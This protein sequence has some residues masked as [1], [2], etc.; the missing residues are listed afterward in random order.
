MFQ[1]NSNNKTL[2]ISEGD[3]S[4]ISYEI[5]EK[6]KNKILDFSNTH[7]VFLVQTQNRFKLNFAQ[8]IQYEDLKEFSN[9]KNG[10]YQ[11]SILNSNTKFNSLKL[12]KP[13]TLSGKLSYESFRSAVEFQKTY[14]GNLL[15]LPLSKEFVLKSGIN[16]KFRGHTEELEKFY[17]TKTVMLMY[18]KE[19]AVIPLT[20]HIPLKE[21]SK[22]TKKV[23]LEFIIQTILNSKIFPNLKIGVCGLN[24]HCGEGGKIGKEE[25][26]WM[27]R[28]IKALKKKYPVSNLISADSIFTKEIRKSF[29]VILAWYHDQGLIPFKAIA[30]KKGINVTLGLP[31]FRVSPDHGPAFDIA[32][33][34]NASPESL[35]SCFQ[36]LE[37]VNA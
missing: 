14:G 17:K 26:E 6:S 18:S 33:K 13:S 28:K 21:V 2:W 30:G 1:P 5:L 20:T 37:Q 25:I 9:L 7:K 22:R 36:F 24:P 34:G 35:E 19:L 8:T 12:G 31:F 15:T 11:I 23:E 10:F 3:V 32:Q 16:S 27:T 29:S 4:G